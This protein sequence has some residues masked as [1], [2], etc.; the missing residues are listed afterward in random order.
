M[1]I[2]ISFLTILFSA[3]VCT[4]CNEKSVESMPKQDESKT[5]IDEWLVYKSRDSKGETPLCKAI[6]ERAQPEVV[7]AILSFYTEKERKEVLNTPFRNKLEIKSP[8]VS[9]DL[10]TAPPH[11]QLERR[12]TVDKKPQP[13]P[14]L[15]TAPRS[16]VVRSIFLNEPESYLSLA[17]KYADASIVEIL[18][19][20]GAEVIPSKTQGD[21]SRAD[22]RKTGNPPIHYAVDRGDPSIISTLL[23]AGADIK[24]LSENGDSPLLFAILKVCG[25][26]EGS[27][28]EIVRMLLKSG[29]DADPEFVLGGKDPL[30]LVPVSCF[31]IPVTKLLL[32]KEI[33]EETLVKA[34][35]FIDEI[36]VEKK[37]YAEWESKE[38]EKLQ[39]ELKSKVESDENRVILNMSSYLDSCEKLES[40]IKFRTNQLA[41]VKEQLLLSDEI[42]G[43]ILKKQ[44]EDAS[45]DTE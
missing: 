22:A 25:N 8:Q 31:N 3:F 6:K 36:I 45:R 30:L 18:L 37:K 23:N 33:G 35:K 26:Y 11:R 29:A 39:Q 4:S 44:K 32:K 43:L 14:E 17:A 5:V 19:K 13:F 40:D 20:A 10:R 34:L 38:I 16:M 12:A 21:E 9:R 1:K 15:R 28:I 7:K 24:A 27:S 2:P 41:T 42:R